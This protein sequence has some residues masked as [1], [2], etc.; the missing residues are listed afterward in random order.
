MTFTYPSVSSSNDSGSS[1]QGIIDAFNAIRER[2]GEIRK[3]YPAS[4]QGIIQAIV[5]LQKWGTADTGDLPT[6][7]EPVYDNDGNL[8]GGNINPLPKNGDLWFDTRQGRLFIWL[9]DGYYQCN[10]ADGIPKVSSTQPAQEVPGS[11]W[12]NTGNSA[13]YIWNG[14]N[15]LQVTAPTGFSTANLPLSN[16]TTATFTNAGNTLP[17]MN[18]QTQEDYNQWLY[19]AL[20]TLESGH[21][22]TAS[23]AQGTTLPSSGDDGELFYKTDTHTLYVCE[24]NNFYPATP[25]PDISNDVSINALENKDS[26]QDVTIAALESEVDG[27]TADVGN[28]QARPANTYTLGTAGQQGGGDGFTPGIWLKEANGALT[29]VNISGAG[30][31][32]VAE[33]QAGITIAAAAIE[34]SIAA[35]EAD[36]V[37]QTEL[38]AV[39]ADVAALEQTVATFGT[40]QSALS[41]DLAAIQAGIA[42]LPSAAD[43]Q[44]RLSAAGGTLAGLIDMAGNKIENLPTPTA[45]F[46][47][48]NRQYV[49]TMD[50]SIRND[51]VAKTN[52]VFQSFKVNNTAVGTPGIDFSASANYGS[53]ALKFKTF[54]PA[55]NHYVTFGTSSNPYEYSW[56]YGSD[57]A[58]NWVKGGNR[59]FSIGDKAYAKELV[60]ADLSANALGPVYTN[61]VDVRSTLASLQT[62]I[63]SSNS[64]SAGL[65]TQINNI[66]YDTDTKNVFYSDAAPTVPL[67]D[68]DLWFDSYN[69][70]LNVRHGGAWVFPDRVEDTQLKTALLNA[71]NTSSDYA[72]LKAN[73]ITALS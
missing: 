17:A 2:E 21:E 64:T 28:L 50:Q 73:L 29:G 57:E 35:L 25:Y 39:E 38:Q 26:S 54:S 1:Y 53:E 13:L 44:A 65:Q 4:Y 30:A 68:G 14:S 34:T 67:E 70:R 24:N 40:T 31:I 58:F 60:L 3:Y 69:L 56:N 63:D 5:D 49:D 71:V 51:T 62:Q 52:S 61:Q 8:I 18:G 27:L 41:T 42:A 6:N 43:V 15:W 48:V 20:T 33:G 12:F 16:P 22:A 47:A 66:N 32:A 55:G 11:L 46:D 37:C 9:D 23:M 36:H 45:P 7:W 72:T 10:G 19:S 59:V